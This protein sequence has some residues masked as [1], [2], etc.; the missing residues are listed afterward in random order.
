MFG[1]LIPKNEVYA[2]P[3]KV[4]SPDWLGWRKATAT[5]D[6][7]CSVR[8]EALESKKSM[9]N[10]IETQGI[11]TGVAG[12][13]PGY[14]TMITIASSINLACVVREKREIENFLEQLD[15]HERKKQSI[16]YK[17]QYQG[18]LK[19]YRYIS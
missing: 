16:T 1:N 8:Q 18:G 14:G 12:C 10:R 5:W 6:C 3:V 15:I 4:E 9:E 2:A 11:G 13:I 19:M 7:I 17:T